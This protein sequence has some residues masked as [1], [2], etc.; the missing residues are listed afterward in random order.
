L[1]ALFFVDRLI[2]DPLARNIVKGV[3]V[4][5]AILALASEWGYAILCSRRWKR[6]IMTLERV[7]MQQHQIEEDERRKGLEVAFVQE[8]QKRRNLLFNLHFRQRHLHAG[9]PP[10]SDA[11]QLKIPPVPQHLPPTTL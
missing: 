5:C 6:D 4:G 8:E 9:T 1:I 3:L 11:P 7:Q 2:I 10:I